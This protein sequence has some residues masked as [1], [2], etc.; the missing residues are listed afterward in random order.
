MYLQ[1]SNELEEKNK[2]LVSSAL[3]VE[4]ELQSLNSDIQ[5]MIGVLPWN[6]SA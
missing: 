2:S 3:S 4:D 1:M 6:I 5:V